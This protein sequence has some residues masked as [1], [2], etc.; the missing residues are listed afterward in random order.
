MTFEDS[1]FFPETNWVVD[2][3]VLDPGA[4][5]SVS[6]EQTGTA[7]GCSPPTPG[8]CEPPF[9]LTACVASGGTC[10]VV[11]RNLVFVYDPVLSGAVASLDYS[12]NRRLHGEWDDPLAQDG[13]G[14]FQGGVA[15]LSGPEVP[16]ATGLWVPVDRNGLTAV[17]FTSEAA[18]HP[19]FS[20]TGQP[21]TFG[22]FRYVTVPAGV[23]T[24]SY[25]LDDWKVTVHPVAADA[26]GAEGGPDG[27]ADAASDANQDADA[28]EGGDGD[29]GD[30]LVEAGDA[31]DADALAEGGDAEPV[32]DAAS[33]AAEGPS[34]TVGFQDEVL[35]VNAWETDTIHLTVVREGDKSSAIDVHYATAGGPAAGF[36]TDPEIDVHASAGTLYESSFGVVEIKAEETSTDIAI[37]VLKGDVDGD[38]LAQRRYLF[39]VELSAP[40]AT[41]KGVTVGLDSGTLR[42]ATTVR[43]K[44]RPSGASGCACASSAC[45]ESPW[46]AGEGAGLALLAGLG[47]LVARRRSRR[48]GARDVR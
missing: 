10:R 33:D 47:V 32:A 31:D 9:R 25:G 39:H 14:V 7:T 29:Q 17:T 1:T 23:V 28:M 2:S 13:L 3:A 6:V 41:G 44:L 15:Y 27:G 20:A 36:A 24:A 4:I 46:S 12:M 37:R 48:R 43:M 35:D 38:D 8:E 5:Y 34:C 26:G 21:L 40:Q 42:T 16:P 19:D 30:A 22:Y 11:D 18:T 45:R